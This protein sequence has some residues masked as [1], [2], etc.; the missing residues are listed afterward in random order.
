[1]YESSGS[2]EFFINITRIQSRPE[3]FTWTNAHN[4][5][6]KNHDGHILA[7]LLLRYKPALLKL[8]HVFIL[9]QNLFSFPRYSNF[10]TS[11]SEI[12]RRHQ[13]PENKS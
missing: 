11:G 6:F 5:C 9:L 7:I 2:S 4:S 1:M 8:G 12:S 3:T 10:K 13:I